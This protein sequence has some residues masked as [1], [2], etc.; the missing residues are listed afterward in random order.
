MKRIFLFLSALCLV[1]ALAAAEPVEIEG[2]V[3]AAKTV[4]LLAP[5]S[6]TVTDVDAEAG[7]ALAAGRALLAIGTEPVCAEFDG[8]VTAVF[9]EPGDAAATV[10]DLYGALCYLE[11][12]ELYTAECTT[13]GAASENE[14]KIIHAG[15]KVYIQ[16]TQNDDREGV[17]VVTK[18]EGKRYSLLVTE[19][20][21]LH[22]NERIKVYREE[23]RHS[24]DCIG[25]GEM[26]R[27]DP[28]PVTGEGS[29]LAV[30][31]R[32]GQRVSR[33]DLLLE[34]VPDG[35]DGLRGGDGTVTMPEDGVILSVSA[36]DGAQV[37]KDAPL[38]A[39]CPAGAIEL[40]CEADEDDLSAIAVGDEMTVTL[41]AYPDAPVKARVTEISSVA[42]EDGGGA[43]FDVT[44]ALPEDAPARIG[45]NATARKD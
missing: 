5:Y 1:P 20:G 17:A 23:R 24:A 14:Y 9:A 29:V 25:S 41:D 2:T 16:S 11:R 4:T 40:V 8:T 30:H 43:T 34:L 45:M 27:I 12:D 26:T 7:D 6:G 31:V 36:E 22:Y 33:G 18:V 21:D 10:Q 13:A 42:Q 3:R 28:V 38:A 37:E 32:A 39:Y 35:L 44:L 15:E 19:T